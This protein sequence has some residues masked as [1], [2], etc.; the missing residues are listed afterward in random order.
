MSRHII[1]LLVIA[2]AIGFARADD[3]SAVAKYTKAAAISHSAKAKREKAASLDAN[4]AQ[5]EI[6]EEKER[7]KS[8]AATLRQE[9]HEAE[10]S[11][12]ELMKEIAP[13]DRA[14]YGR[15]HLW[16]FDFLYRWEKSADGKYL[17][18]PRETVLSAERH[19]LRAA[20]DP[21]KD[22][23]VQG[24]F[25]LARLYRDHSRIE[26]AKKSLAIVAE[27]HP[28]YHLTLAQWAKIQNEPEAVAKHAKAAAAS[29]QA[30]L[31]KDLDDHE[32]RGGLIEC[33]ILQAQFE[34]AK[35]LI[36][37]GVT[38]AKKPEMIESYR[39]KMVQAH[40]ALY[41]A[42]VN[43]DSAEAANERFE[44]LDQ[45]MNLDPD[46]AEVFTRL[47][48]LMRDPG[49][50]AEKARAR[51]RATVASGKE[52]AMVYLFL[53]IDAHQS[54]KPAEART[55]WEKALKLSPG[56]PLIANNLA[57]ALAFYEP[58]DLPRAL[59]LVDACVKHSPD[60]ARYRGTRGHVLAKMKRYQEALPDLQAAIKTYP[61][62]AN[63]FRALAET[64]EQ[65][66][67]TV[68]AA[69]YKKRADEL[70][71]TKPKPP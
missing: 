25:G 30:R 17:P 51:L 29:F 26:D 58:V 1:P 3:D 21:D 70:K 39:K 53:G 69:E 2:S 46:N 28:E 11:A 32:A 71:E 48:K 38:L 23:R 27:K 15:A 60:E 36:N 22:V 54:E 6:D 4:V 24:H 18:L 33:L 45:A 20:E 56:A 37:L 65:L 9:A 14:G 62:D 10:Q 44:Q 5:T 63:L 42:K 61:N 7:I 8:E 43:D 49:P 34:E 55:Y 35:K 40:L 12:L 66:G 52:S 41:D 59:E 57:W 13:E 16:M 19:A 47:V 64:A 67:L 31:K 50:V 68:L